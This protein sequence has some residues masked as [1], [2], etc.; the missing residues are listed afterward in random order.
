MLALTSKD[1]K[2]QLKKADIAGLQLA[3]VL[4]YPVKQAILVQ[5]G[6]IPDPGDVFGKKVYEVARKKFNCQEWTGQVE[7][8]GFKC[9]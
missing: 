1:I 9:L 6:L 7:G 5:K 8:Y 2:V 4:A 3:D